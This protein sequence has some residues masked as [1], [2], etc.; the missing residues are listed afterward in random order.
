LLPLQYCLITIEH[1]P[2]I[3]SAVFQD[4]HGKVDITDG[5]RLIHTDGTGFI[6]ENLAKKCP[7]RII[8]GKKSKVCTLGPV[9]TASVFLKETFSYYSM[10]LI[11][12]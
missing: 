1:T 12:G 2:C 4:K 10:F 9:S 8:K 6:S 3:F 11:Y 5:K 7:N